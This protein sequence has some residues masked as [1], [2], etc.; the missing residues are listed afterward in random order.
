MEQV[1]ALLA[2]ARSGRSAA[3]VLSG[4]AGLGK[5]ALLR[6]AAALADEQGFRVLEATS[7]ESE[8]ELAFAGLAELLTPV[9]DLR[10]RLPAAQAAALDSALA[11]APEAGD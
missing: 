8:A 3:L 5:T 7:R 11:L 4:S 6:A 1:E 2:A 9:L 10:D